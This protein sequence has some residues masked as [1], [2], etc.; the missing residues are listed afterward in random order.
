MKT[1]L[2]V[3]CLLSA[4][5]TLQA[6]DDPFTAIRD[7]LAR[8]RI[9]AAEAALVPLTEAASPD[10]RSW[11]FLSQVRA[12]Q[13]Q[14]KEA[15]KLA[16]RA[17]A[18]DPNQAEFQSNLGMTLGQRA[19]E[20][21]F[22]QQALLAG[23][24]LAA[25]KRSVELDPDHLAGYIGLARYYT[26]APS[27]AGGGREPAE[28]YAREVE[29]RHSQLGTIELARIAERFDDPAAAYALFTKAAM[30]EPEAAWVQESL[31]RVSEK[32]QQTDDA[33]AHY[34]KALALDPKRTRAKDALARLAGAAN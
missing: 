2:L 7:D 16:E 15:I 9:D 13:K 22:M 28:R 11:F 33:R 27:I 6:A 18:A 17:V 21:N 1:K 25:F 5:G 26:N 30:A 32:L 4:I 23:R 20:V 14:T 8:N 31:G 19:G 10:P 24:M 12:R 3:L 29:K 34:E